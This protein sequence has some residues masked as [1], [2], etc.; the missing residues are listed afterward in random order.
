MS[1]S[2]LASE[3]RRYLVVGAFFIVVSIIAGIFIERNCI[4]S[5]GT[6][7]EDEPSACA[8]NPFDSG[9]VHFLNQFSNKSTEFDFAL[10]Q[11]TGIFL[12][13]AGPLV[14]L[15]WYLWFIQDGEQ[16][17]RREYVLSTIV[18]AVIAVVVARLLARGLP[19]R[20]RP[21]HTPDFDFLVPFGFSGELI[22]WSS[23]P[24]DH[25]VLLFALATGIFLV[26][27][28]LGIL[29]MVYVVVINGLPRIYLGIHWPTD[30]IF[31]STLGLGMAIWAAIPAVR[32][33]IKAP[34]QKLIAFSP[35]LFYAGLFLVTVEI[36]TMFNDVRMLA[37]TLFDVVFG[38]H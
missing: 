9:I 15:L 33:A 30:V 18:V 37:S 10:W 35:G 16:E 38:S 34:I 11:S 4:L 5:G 22:E 25:M 2:F 7:T 8:V 28:R 32:R 21:L 31:G 17:K 13:K 1:T 19:F 12:V 29:S 3:T 24:S 26:S 14:A 36:M 20:P 23:F 6:T 27:R